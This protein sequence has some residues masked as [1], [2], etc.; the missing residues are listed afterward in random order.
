MVGGSALDKNKSIIEF[1]KQQA[2]YLQN[3]FICKRFM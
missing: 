1:N 2:R 3:V